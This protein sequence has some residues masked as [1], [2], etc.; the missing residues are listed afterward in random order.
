MAAHK[1]RLGATRVLSFASAA[2]LRESAVGRMLALAQC[3]PLELGGT[4]PTDALDH[5]RM[6]EFA[7]ATDPG[8]PALGRAA[9]DARNAAYNWRVQCVDVAATALLM[10]EF[11]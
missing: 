3:L 8:A 1:D 6:S 7:A 10:I 5:V 11:I 9:T 2:H 4:V